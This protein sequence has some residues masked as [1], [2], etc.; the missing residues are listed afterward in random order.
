M[1]AS[2]TPSSGFSLDAAAGA[3]D[4]TRFD[5][6][7][8]IEEWP[9]PSALYAASNPNTPLTA[10]IQGNPGGPPPPPFHDPYNGGFTYPSSQL[11][12]F[13]GAYPFYYNPG[14]VPGGCAARTLTATCIKNITTNSGHTLNFYDEPSN[15]CLPGG[16]G[17]FSAVCGFTAPLSPAFM[18][19]T[20]ALVGIIRTTGLPS[21]PLYQWSWKDNFNGTVSQ[22]GG[23]Y[24]VVT[25]NSYPVDPASG[26][27][28]VTI[29]SING[30]PQVP[31]SISC[32]TTPSTLWPPNGKSVL[33][34][35]SGT[36]T[37]G[38]SSLSSVTLLIP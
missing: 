10:G 19:F 26:S 17:T 9:T 27:G 4:F 25:A 16:S 35:I 8:L 22:G 15:K 20:T 5:W 11:P 31:P 14:D 37:P 24:D 38:T 18:Q 1:Q 23:V 34:T 2:F 7:Q 6:V 3:C 12:P 29:T 33:V 32:M 28:G 36:I 13:L 21:D 30:V